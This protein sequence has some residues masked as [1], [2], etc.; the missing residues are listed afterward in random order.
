MKENLS[1]KLSDRL[2]HN[3]EYHVLPFRFSRPS[4]RTS[5]Y[6]IFVTKHFKGFEIMRE[7]MSKS[8]S[9]F[10]DGVGN[11]SFIPVDKDKIREESYEQLNL[12]TDYSLLLDELGDNLLRDFSEQTLRMKSIYEK[13]SINKRFI[14]TNYKEALKRLEAVGK[15]LTSPSH[16]DRQKRKGEV[17]FADSV[18]VTFLKYE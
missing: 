14:K 3:Q 12:L 16:D 7:I 5:H 13:H 17:T 11:F 10:D 1:E 18:N 6:L 4:R 15:I 8:S 9:E 2:S